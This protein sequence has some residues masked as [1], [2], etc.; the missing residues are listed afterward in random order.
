L[1]IRI[2]GLTRPHQV[3][4]VSARAPASEGPKQDTDR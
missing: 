4:R 1:L 2:P 3:L